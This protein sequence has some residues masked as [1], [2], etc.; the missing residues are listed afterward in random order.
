MSHPAGDPVAVRPQTLGGAASRAGTPHH[1]SAQ[2]D[3]PSSPTAARNT[4]GSAAAAGTM[5]SRA[6]AGRVACTRAYVIAAYRQLARRQARSYAR[7]RSAPTA[8]TAARAWAIPS[9]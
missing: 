4:V 5:A 3:R 2:C 8:D 9:D 1:D 7:G 6:Q